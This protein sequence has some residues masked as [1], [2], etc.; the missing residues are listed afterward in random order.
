MADSTSGDRPQRTARE[1]GVPVLPSR[2]SGSEASGALSS[3]TVRVFPAARSPGAALR[4][5]PD[6]WKVGERRRPAGEE[7]LPGSGPPW[8]G[9]GQL[10]TDSE[11]LWKNAFVS[12][13]RSQVDRLWM[14][15]A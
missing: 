2:W 8:G 6:C 11:L 9:L 13:P 14:R 10:A 7:R 4:Q 1:G 3:S 12:D 15:P 5:D